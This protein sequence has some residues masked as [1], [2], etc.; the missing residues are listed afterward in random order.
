MSAEYSKAQ[1]PT[2]AKELL[3]IT[4]LS[5]KE[6]LDSDNEDMNEI[7]KEY[8]GD[9]HPGSVTEFHERL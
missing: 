5:D 8:L 1:S 4:Q 3:D 9:N 6:L 7:M 2:D